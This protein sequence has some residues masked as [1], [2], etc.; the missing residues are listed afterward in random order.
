MLK[1]ECK[2]IAKKDELLCKLKP[3]LEYAFDFDL[4]KYT[5]LA[6]VLSVYDPKLN[7]S[8]VRMVPDDV[9]EAEFWRNFFYHIELWKQTQGFENNLG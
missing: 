4:E 3:H 6:T 2:R 1:K 9:T 7:D 5:F 8:L